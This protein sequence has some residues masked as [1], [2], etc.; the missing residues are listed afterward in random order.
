M[1]LRRKSSRLEGRRI[2]HCVTGSVAAVEA[3]RLARELQRH[4]ALVHAYMTKDA[5]G[6]IHPNIMEFATGE[7]VVTELTGKM[8]HLRGYDLVLIAPATAT[9]I[10]K[11]AHGIADSAVTALSLATKAKILIAPAMDLGMYESQAMRANVELLKERGCSF[12]EPKVEEGK[13]KLAAME[14]VV[15]ACIHALSEK[16]LSGKR[17]IVTA[18]PTIEYID[19][20]RIISN[21]SSGRMGMEMAK[22]A[23]FRGAQVKLVY[24]RGF[25]EPPRYLNVSRVETATEMLS[26][27]RKGARDGCDFFIAA[28][29]VAD[30][31]PRKRAEKIVS[32]KGTL[33]LELHPTPKILE[34]A[35]SFRAVRMAFKVLHNASRKELEAAA[36]RALT[37]YRV[38]IAVANDAGKAMGSPENEV[39]IAT[40]DGT[41]YVPSMPKA[42]VAKILW[43]IA[44][45]TKRK[46]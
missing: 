1:E 36:K 20:I 14:E 25:V 10:G 45:K 27:V 12:V 28:A 5:A 3:P 39:C 37:E 8:E 44:A 15:D 24:G 35:R 46:R 42:D 16:D 18:G 40:R 9:T 13:A 26:Q 34:E 38:E 21:K 11:I 7:R 33:K 31:A 19:P 32:S 30:F 41:K 4:G 22:E 17:V 43:D 2:A 29:A 23:Y 6:I